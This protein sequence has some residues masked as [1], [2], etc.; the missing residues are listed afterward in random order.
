MMECKWVWQEKA[1]PNSRW[2]GVYSDVWRK[3]AREIHP[4]ELNLEAKIT[5]EIRKMNTKKT[6]ANRKISKGLQIKFGINIGMHVK[7]K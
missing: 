3:S 6:N 7:Q 1:I 4:T 2:S 5:K